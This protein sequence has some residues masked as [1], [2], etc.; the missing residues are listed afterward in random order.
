M[1]GRGLWEI[2][3]DL[4]NIGQGTRLPPEADFVRTNGMYAYQA[5]EYMELIKKILILA[6]FL[7]CSG[8]QV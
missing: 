5:F 6:C 8:P 4:Q 3:R 2:T 1:L 7:T